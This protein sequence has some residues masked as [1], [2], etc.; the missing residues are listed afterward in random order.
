MRWCV[1]VAEA[2]RGEK[3]PLRQP[4]VIWGTVALSLALLGGALIIWLADR[5]RKRLVQNRSAAEE[6][7]EYRQLLERGE[8]T[9][10][11][12]ERLRARVSQRLRMELQLPAG[13]A[14]PAATAPPAASATEPPAASGPSSPGPE[15]A[16][17]SPPRR[18]A[19][20]LTEKSSGN[21]RRHATTV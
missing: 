20:G 5:W 17:P 21:Q 6:L 14:A 18:W 11:E 12:Y 9:E 19:R 16:S 13:S 1:L 4:E 10:E 7:S 8:I 2:V 15:G 3:D